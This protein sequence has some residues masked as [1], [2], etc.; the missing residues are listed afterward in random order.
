MTKYHDDLA[1]KNEQNPYNPLL[2]NKR[3]QAGNII[4]NESF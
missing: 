3:D 2:K 4:F 1:S